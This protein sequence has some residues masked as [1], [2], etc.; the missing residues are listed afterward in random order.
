MSSQSLDP[1]Y[2]EASDAL[3]SQLRDRLTV[4]LSPNNYGEAQGYAW[5]VAKRRGVPGPAKARELERFRYG[6]NPLTGYGVVIMWDPTP[7]PP[8]V[9]ELLGGSAS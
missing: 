3:T 8:Q 6:V 4:G 2:I 1:A 9:T 5:E 7:P